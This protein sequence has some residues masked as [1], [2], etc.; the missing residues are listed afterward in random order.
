MQDF[1]NL[2]FG[3]NAPTSLPCLSS[4]NQRQLSNYNHKV[5]CMSAQRATKRS[6]SVKP[7]EAEV[8]IE[9]APSTIHRPG[10]PH[11][12]KV[13]SVETLAGTKGAVGEICHIVLEHGGRFHFVEGQ[14]L[15]VILHPCEIIFHSVSFSKYIFT[16]VCDLSLSVNPLLIIN[17]QDDI[18][19]VGPLIPPTRI[20]VRDFPIASCRDGDFFMARHSV[21]VF[22]VQNCHRT[23]SVTFSVMLK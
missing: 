6:A 21:Y 10:W 22:V 2:S 12:T 7:T 3:N 5:L 11:C 14:Y 1:S 23:V 18:G 8:A 13:V 9:E 20:I 19:P 16:Y 17:L 4:E 15:G